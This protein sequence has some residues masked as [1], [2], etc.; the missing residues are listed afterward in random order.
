V[1]AK[2]L[3]TVQDLAKLNAAKEAARHCLLAADKFL[4]ESQFE[5]AK[6]QLEKAR[7]LDPSNAYIYAFQDRIAYFEEKKKKDVASGVAPALTTP[8]QYTI[9]KPII[10][11]APP[12]PAQPPEHKAEGVVA[13]P[14]PA[15]ASEEHKKGEA[16]SVSPPKVE[17]NEPSDRKSTRLN[18]SHESDT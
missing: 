14:A 9:P 17:K 15:P 4:K 12:T 3:N 18:S 1:S 2:T 11:P 13:N 8:T 10:K 5:L 16:A 6:Q 7:E